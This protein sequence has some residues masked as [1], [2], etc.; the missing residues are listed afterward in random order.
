MQD[1]LSIVR[2]SYICLFLAVLL[3]LVENNSLMIV[4]I[5]Q[6]SRLLRARWNRLFI[7]RWFFWISLDFL[8]GMWIYFSVKKHDILENSRLSSPKKAAIK[9]QPTFFNP[10]HQQAN[11]SA[12]FLHFLNW[13]L[14]ITMHS[15]LWIHKRLQIRHKKEE[16]H[17]WCSRYFIAQEFNPGTSIEILLEH[18]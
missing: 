5:C 14:K 10:K 9:L 18:F 4:I 6:H 17:L 8:R 3:L 11:F 7:Q 2:K 1:I 12:F 16:I 13:S 15:S